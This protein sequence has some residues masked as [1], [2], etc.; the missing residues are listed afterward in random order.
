MYDCI[1]T[2]CVFAYNFLFVV[3]NAAASFVAIVAIGQQYSNHCI[4][5]TKKQQQTQNVCTQKVDLNCHVKLSCV[6]SKKI[7][8]YSFNH[9]MYTC[10]MH[11]KHFHGPGCEHLQILM[12][13]IFIYILCVLY[14]CT[15]DSNSTFLFFYFL[16]HKL[17]DLFGGGMG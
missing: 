13:N 3:D 8:L 17:R 10:I 16:K 11:A 6:L 1:C 2:A 5:Y 4:L 9:T 12:P 7:Y 15:S 14:E